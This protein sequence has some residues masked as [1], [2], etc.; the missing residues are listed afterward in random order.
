MLTYNILST[1]ELHI[2]ARTQK[3]DTVPCVTRQFYDEKRKL[4]VFF[5]IT[6]IGTITAHLLT[7]LLKVT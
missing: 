2:L 7:P 5:L 1:I 3:S 6:I 4:S